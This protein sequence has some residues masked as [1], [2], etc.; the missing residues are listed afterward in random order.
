[1]FDISTLGKS[2]RE[3]RPGPLGSLCFRLLR[4]RDAIRHDELKD[5]QT[6]RESA[7][8][9]DHDLVTWAG[10]LPTYAAVD[11]PAGGADETYFQGKCHVYSN[12]QVA[13]AWNNWRTLRIV[14]NQMIIRHEACPDPVDITYTSSSIPIIRQLSNDICMSA[15]SF[16]GSPRKWCRSY[17]Y[18]S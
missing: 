6:I 14:V 15:A 10:S 18:A 2:R 11:V 17:L 4:L 16:A 7:A 9:I 1:M 13:Q 8:E 12:L 5:R 3:S